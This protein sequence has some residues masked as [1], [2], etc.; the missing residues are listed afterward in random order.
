MQASRAED[1]QEILSKITD[2]DAFNETLQ[3]LVLDKS[4]ILSDWHELDAAHQMQET[5][6]LLK[7]A[8]ADQGR[9]VVWQ[10]WSR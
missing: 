7:W 1:V 4:G 8:V 10:Y 3:K 6:A 5:G 2:I 9:G